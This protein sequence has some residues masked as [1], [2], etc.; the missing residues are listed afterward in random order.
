MT[1]ET[2]ESI[3]DGASAAVKN[4]ILNG[5]LTPG[6]TFSQVE[7]AA[8]LNVS[9]TPLR[10]AIRRLEQE[11][12][13]VVEHNQRARVA[14]LALDE[15]EALYA[16]RI[17]VEGLAA[18]VTIPRLTPEDLANMEAELDRSEKAAAEGDAT[19]WERAHAAFHEGLIKYANDRPVRDW[20]ARLSD[21]T[22]RY[23]RLKLTRT[24]EEWL[25]AGTDH[26]I[27]FA[28][29]KTGEV[30]QTVDLLARHYSRT[31][32]SVL[33]TESS[34]RDGSLIHAAYESITGLHGELSR[35]GW[36]RRISSLPSPTA[37]E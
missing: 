14:P 3:V 32:F 35:A 6:A 15:M 28:S 26:R 8:Q 16:L 17:V 2:K 22:E 5:T 7:L 37:K 12:L 30:K 29:A 33:R 19:A 34:S 20:T 18:T 27:L 9:R 36:L 31:V 4:L 24:P 10:E 1:S 11:G 21:Q 23:R 13:I 25:R